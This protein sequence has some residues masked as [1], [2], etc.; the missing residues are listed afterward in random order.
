MTLSLSEEENVCSSQQEKKKWPFFLL[1]SLLLPSPDWNHSKLPADY[2]P[3][4]GSL[5]RPP[6]DTA[7]MDT[8]VSLSPNCLKLLLRGS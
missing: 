1:L 6:A 2:C 7:A 8:P 4:G 3:E 5:S